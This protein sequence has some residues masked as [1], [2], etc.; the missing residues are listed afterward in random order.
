MRTL[1]EIIIIIFRKIWKQN[2][3]ENTNYYK[4]NKVQMKE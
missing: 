2:E 3:I 1:F 4:I